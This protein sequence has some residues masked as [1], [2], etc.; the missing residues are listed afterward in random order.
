MLLTAHPGG[1]SYIEEAYLIT[2]HGDPSWSLIA[3]ELGGE[4]ITITK[5]LR[6]K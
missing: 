1:L 2:L 3:V 5:M 6:F 4:H